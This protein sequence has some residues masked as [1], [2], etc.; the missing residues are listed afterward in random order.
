MAVSLRSADPA[1]MREMNIALI[2]ECLRRE[3]PLSRARLALITGLNKTT[4][5]SLVRELLEASFVLETG[6]AQG[7]TG[8][9]A[10]CLELNPR[11]GSIIGAEIGVDFVSVALADFSAHILWA[12]KESTIALGGQ[13]AI[14]RRTIEILRS[15]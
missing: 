13:E 2:L 12:H 5:S 10:I 6:L 14:L 3:S 11:A 8:R 1:L 4:V 15:P 9:P 7:G